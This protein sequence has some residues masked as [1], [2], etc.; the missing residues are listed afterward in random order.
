MSGRCAW[1]H[2]LVGWCVVLLEETRYL[3]VIY[4]VERRQRQIGIKYC[5]RNGAIASAHTPWCGCGCSSRK[6]KL[7]LSMKGEPLNSGVPNNDIISAP[8]PMTRSSMPDM[9]EAAAKL[10]VVMPDPQKRSRV[11]ALAF[12][13]KPASR[14]DMRP[15]SPLCLPRWELVPQRMSSTSAVSSLLR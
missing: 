9:M 4:R 8:P 10:T 15:R 11:I 5:L 6:C 2:V 7:P 1:S 3:R 12:V 14:A 13:S